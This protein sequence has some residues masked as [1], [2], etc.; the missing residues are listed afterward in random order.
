MRIITW[1]V[2]GLRACEKKGFQEFFERADADYFCVQETKM[3]QSQLSELPFL[4]KDRRAFFCDAQKRGYSGT[5]VFAKEEPEAV[6]TDPVLGSI[7]GEGRVLTL[8]TKDFYLVNGYV[9]NARRDLCRLP[10]R[11]DWEDAMR[12][13]LTALDK[14][15]PVI[16]CGDL[17][18]A[19]NPIDLKNA[20]ANEGSAGYTDAEREKF[21]KLLESGF[22]DAFR[23]LYPDR[24]DAYTWWSYMGRAREKNVGWRIDYFVVSRRIV[25]KIQDVKIHGEVFGSDHCPV[26]LLINF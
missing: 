25:P 17:N 15:L 26:E 16:Y 2:N 3:Q 10:E 24:A 7:A 20:K 11:E 14:D 22:A 9:P 21:S 8:K 6:E 5:A 19:H 1:N 4:P 18:V 12:G 23:A 13:Y